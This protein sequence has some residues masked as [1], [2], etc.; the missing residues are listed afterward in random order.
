[1]GGVPQV[2]FAGGD[3]W[4]Y[5]F[6]GEK[7]VDGR[8]ELL[9]K[10]D[11]NPKDSK[12]V[13]GGRGTRNNLIATPVIYDG[14]VYISVGQDPEHGEGVGHVWC[15]DPTKRGDVSPQLVFNASD[16]SRPAPHKRIQAAVPEQGDIVRD[17]PNSAMVW[18]YNEYD[19]NG[20]DFEEKMHRT[21]ATAAIKDDL[22]Y[23]AD[24]SGLF[25]CLDAKTGRSYW[26]HDL[27]AACWGS[28]LI[29]D[30]HVYVGDEEGKVTIFKHG[31]EKEIL[32]EVQMGNS[33]YSTP[34]VAN[35]TLFIANKTHLFSI[36]SAAE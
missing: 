7:S 11:C 23:V 28:A 15:I 13:L 31:K 12:W 1:L 29:V 14:N 22:L 19:W 10:F 16:P 27:F 18:H 33:I 3:G 8:P 6:D 20:D 34:V 17:N 9:W 4:L 2:L 24:F 35:N 30:G 25:H 32:N 21:I 5:S 26:T 36:G